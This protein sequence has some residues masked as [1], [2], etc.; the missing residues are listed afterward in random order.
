LDWDVKADHS[1]LRVR[2]ACADFAAAQEVYQATLAWRTE[3]AKEVA[4]QEPA[5]EDDS[6]EMKTLASARSRLGDEQAEQPFVETTLDLFL[7][8][9]V[10]PAKPAD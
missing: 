7:P 10:A 8:F 6:P 9:A 1:T 3:F 2:S 5:S 4:E